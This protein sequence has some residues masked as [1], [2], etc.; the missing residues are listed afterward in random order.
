MKKE[1]KKEREPRRSRNFEYE[2][3]REY[4]RFNTE[5]YLRNTGAKR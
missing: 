4:E 1:E 3:I 2:K 5:R